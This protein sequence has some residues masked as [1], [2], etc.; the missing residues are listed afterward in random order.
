MPSSVTSIAVSRRVS[1]RPISTP[2]CSM[3]QSGSSRVSSSVLAPS[4]VSVTCASVSDLEDVE[5]RDALQQRVE[6]EPV[7]ALI[8]G[9]RALL[10]V[11][12]RRPG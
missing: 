7:D 4:M 6:D 5:A 8:G 3:S 9:E 11:A 2:D 1:P 12:T 10:R